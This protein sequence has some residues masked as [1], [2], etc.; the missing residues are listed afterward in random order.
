MSVKIAKK[1]VKVFG[2]I[3]KQYKDGSEQVELSPVADVLIQEPAANVGVTIGLTK[4]LGDYNSIKVSV[5][6]H[7]PCP[8]TPE[9]IE[10]IY[11]VVL[12]WVDGKI[13][14]IDNELN[15]KKSA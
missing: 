10:D 12:E 3:K 5:S 6:L 8:P 9:G 13:T 14:A 2:E 15:S 11:A 7:M 4:N 1:G